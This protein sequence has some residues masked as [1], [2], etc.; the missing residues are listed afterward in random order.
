MDLNEASDPRP[1][2]PS[3]WYPDPAADGVIRYW[4]G[5]CWTERTVPRGGDGHHVQVGDLEP[6]ARHGRLS[7]TECTRVWA[8]AHTTPLA[9]VGAAILVSTVTMV[10]TRGEP[11]DQAK[12]TSDLMKQ[13]NG[14]PEFARTFGEV[15]LASRVHVLDGDRSQRLRNRRGR[16]E[17]APRTTVSTPVQGAPLVRPDGSVTG[18][19]AA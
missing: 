16:L 17:P 14:V 4:D 18:T 15:S 3:G 2:I 12:E 6:P 13:L 5:L 1:D 11:F 9:V 19:R 7:R 10:A 8:K